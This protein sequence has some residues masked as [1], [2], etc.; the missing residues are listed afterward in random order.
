[1]VRK[2]YVSKATLWKCSNAGDQGSIPGSGISLGE[3]NG[4]ILQYSCLGNPMNREA[5]GATVHG[6]AESDMTE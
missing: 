1:M 5:W 2:K 3:G 6:V 4:K